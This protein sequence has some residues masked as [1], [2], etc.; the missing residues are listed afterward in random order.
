MPLYDHECES[1]GYVFEE[2]KP[3]EERTLPCPK[4]DGVAKR[5]VSPMRGS[6]IDV[7]QPQHFEELGDDAP[8]ISSKAQLASECERRGLVSRYLIEGYR[9]HDRRRWM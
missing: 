6:Q 8:Y 2:V 4:C 9:N 3:Y 1:C 5:I 7:F